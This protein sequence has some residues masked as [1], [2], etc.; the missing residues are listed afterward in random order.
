[1]GFNKIPGW[2]IDLMQATAYGLTQLF[3]VAL[4]FVL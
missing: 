2:L 1:M 3:L 4:H